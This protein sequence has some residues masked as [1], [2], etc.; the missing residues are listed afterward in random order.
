MAKDPHNDISLQ[1]QIQTLE[2][3]LDKVLRANGKDEKLS[4]LNEQKNVHDFLRSSDFWTTIFE[5]SDKNSEIVLKSVAA[6]G[7]GPIIFQQIEK[8]EDPLPPLR[9]LIEILKEVE[10]FY[11]TMGGI[12]GYHA[13][14][15]K[16]MT[17]KG[18]ANK[19]KQPINFIHPE[20][21][22][23]TV[24][25]RAVHRSIRWGIEAMP[26]MA[27]IYPV[28]GAGDRL[29]LVDERT[30]EPLPAAQLQFGGKSLLEGLIRD[31]QGREF[32]FYKLMGYFL[33]TPIAM[34]TSKEKNNSQHI[35]NI[36]KDRH[37]FGRP[38]ESFLFFIQ[39]SMP[40]VTLEGNWS[41]SA[42][43]KLTLKPGGHGMMWKLAQEKKIF[44]HLKQKG[45]FKALVRQINNPVAGVDNGL[46]ALTGI[47]VKENK[48]FGFASCRRRLKT[49]EGVNVV[50]EKQV[51]DGFEYCL[52]NIEYTDFEKGE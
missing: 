8:L 14:V 51:K 45:R 17:H 40:V 26:K 21:I 5:K 47:G 3:L 30:G 20:G 25:D 52:T 35:H 7:Q 12:I 48:A 22:D 10:D 33:A 15:L 13:T 4:I 27:E 37:W 24:D 29:R 6:I 19:E 2:P 28:G 23:L 39:P 41:V 46:L 18:E 11:D 34:M 31:L 9:E 50:V 32:L 36:C 16:L 44:E 43:L 1:K 49:P 38:K 42:P